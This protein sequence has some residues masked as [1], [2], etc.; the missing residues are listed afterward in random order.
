ME[1]SSKSLRLLRHFVN[2]TRTWRLVKADEARMPV[3]IPGRC[4]CPENPAR[5][6]RIARACYEA[7]ESVRFLEKGLVPI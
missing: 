3:S 7:S 5:S 1:K 6:V 4:L 2:K